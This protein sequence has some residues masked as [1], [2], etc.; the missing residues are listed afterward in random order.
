MAKAI[1]PEVLSEAQALREAGFTVLSISQ[2]L[3]VS[4]RALQR[5]FAATGIKKGAIRDEL[6]AKARADLVAHITSNDVIRA[7][8]AK[9]LADNI[10]HSQ[11]LRAI[12]VDASVHMKANS[13]PDVVLVARAAAAYATT[14]KATSDAVRSTLPLDR[15]G[16][17]GAYDLPELVITVISDQEAAE[18]AKR[19]ALGMSD[20]QPAEVDDDE[21][22]VVEEG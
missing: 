22:G 11:H 10:A 7:Q 12:L 17:D 3:H 14:L 5:H 18:I 16:D 15:L 21:D 19:A 13:L 20:P 2:R 8:V 4:V 6:L 9:L 1:S